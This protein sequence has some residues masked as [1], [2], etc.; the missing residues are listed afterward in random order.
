MLQIE[1][2]NVSYTKTKPILKDLN[3]SIQK[4]EI[5]GILGM[6]GAG[7]TTFFKTLY[8]FINAQQGR[9][10]FDGKALQQSQISFLET[11]NFFY[12][13]MRAE[14]YLDILTGG[15][16]NPKFNNIFE[17]PLQNLVDTYSTGM[18]KRLAFW[19]IMEL[20]SDIVILD[21][22]FNGVDIESVECFY[23]LIQKMK[24]AGKTILI[25]SHIIESLTRICDRIAYLNAGVIQH[26][27]DK[28]NYDSL[29][30]TI[31]NTIQD[32]IERA[33]LLSD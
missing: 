15:N 23:M 27:Y 6:N 20:P 2:L 1:N 18:K 16:Y 19:G 3:L 30:N 13:Y 7:K 25:S 8:G 33:F 29:N 17:L 11:E 24:A 5:I 22:P 21:E 32:K 14:E 12:T 4:G 31:R 9:I 26:I 10:T 28:T